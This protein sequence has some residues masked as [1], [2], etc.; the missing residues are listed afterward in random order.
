MSQGAGNYAQ[1]KNFKK[2]ASDMMTTEAQPTSTAEDF[3]TTTKEMVGVTWIFAYSF[4]YMKG[5]FS[6]QAKV[7]L[8]E[9]ELMGMILLNLQGM[10]GID[11][12]NLSML[13]EVV[14][15]IVADYMS[16]EDH[17][18]RR[19]VD[20]KPMFKNLLLCVDR[21]YATKLFN[22]SYDN[23]KTMGERVEHKVA[24]QLET[25]IPG[26]TNYYTGSSNEPSYSAFHQLP[27]SSSEEVSRN[28]LRATRVASQIA[29][30]TMQEDYSVTEIR[31]MTAIMDYNWA[32]LAETPH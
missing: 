20:Y 27:A 30:A 21:S 8:Q 10:Y 19:D 9:S 18:K 1:E 12:S 24:S 5:V 31:W 28:L 23:L 22:N 25:M 2:K 17:F 7:E 32:K 6:K 29:S 13:K 26:S 3:I 15:T 4:H 16:R 14:K 11:E